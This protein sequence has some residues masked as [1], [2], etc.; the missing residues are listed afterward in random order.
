MQGVMMIITN[1]SW[2]VYLSK[3]EK[4]PLPRW[5]IYTEILVGLTTLFGV[6]ITRIM[7]KDLK[8]EIFIYLQEKA[9][10]T[11]DNLKFHLQIQE[12]SLR[13]HMTAIR[14]FLY[15]EDY[16]ELNRYMDQVC[17][18]LQKGNIRNNNNILI[19]KTYFAKKAES[20]TFRKTKVNVIFN[21]ALEHADISS[22]ELCD[23][24][25]ALLEMSYFLYNRIETMDVVFDEDLTDYHIYISGTTDS[26]WR[27][28]PKEDKYLKN[29]LANKGFEISKLVKENRLDI[30]LIIKKV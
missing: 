20:K 23:C 5:G 2:A 26:D 10:Q 22:L 7:V 6:Y 14:G 8:K 13:N 17:E 24:M 11:Y 25:D 29:K 1:N 30:H 3:L 19:M 4:Y 21:S 12:G 15:M 9:E 16:E 27:F 28:I 18:Q